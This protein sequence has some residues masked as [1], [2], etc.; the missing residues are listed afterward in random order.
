MKKFRISIKRLKEAI[1]DYEYFD[2]FMHKMCNASVV[3]KNVHISETHEAV[4]ADVTLEFEDRSETYRDCYYDLKNM[5]ER[6]R[7]LNERKTK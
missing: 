3:A 2:N 7:K 4:H 1:E 6:A 5:T